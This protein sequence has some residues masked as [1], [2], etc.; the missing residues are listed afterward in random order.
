MGRLKYFNQPNILLRS[1]K[2]V[3]GTPKDWLVKSRLSPCED[4]A[5][6][7]AV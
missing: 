7:E 3:P 2:C 6:L 4:S 5:T 1:I